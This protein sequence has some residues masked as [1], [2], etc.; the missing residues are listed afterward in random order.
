MSPDDS[1][2]PTSSDA[3]FHDTAIGEVTAMDSSL[4]GTALLV[5][6][7]LAAAQPDEGAEA[8]AKERALQSATSSISKYQDQHSPL[9]R[10]K[11]ALRRLFRRY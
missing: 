9:N 11:S 6:G 10:V 8:A 5:H 3:D 7:V 1:V 4:E 2:K